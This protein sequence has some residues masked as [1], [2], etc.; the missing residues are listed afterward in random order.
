[1]KKQIVAL[2]L[3][4]VLVLSG[5]GANQ[6]AEETTTDTKKAEKDVSV[7][8]D[9]KKE[10]T[11]E[12]KAEEPVKLV[13]YSYNPTSPDDD[14]V[15]EQLN[16]YLREKINVEIEPHFLTG[17]DYKEKV[18]IQI[19]SGNEVD[20]CFTS[21]WAVNYMQHAGKGAFAEIGSLMDENAP[22]LKAFLGE[23]ILESAKVDGKLYGIPTY[24]DLATQFVYL[25]RKD[26]VEKYGMDV[27]AVKTYADIEPMLAVIKENEPD[28]IPMAYSGQISSL[29]S[30]LPFA[31]LS[32]NRSFPVGIEY[33]KGADSGIV[34]LY[35]T[36]M[37]MEFAKTMNRWYE[38][39]Y[40]PEDVVTKKDFT[41]EHKAGLLFAQTTRYQP[42]YE[43]TLAAMYGYE[44]IAVPIMSPTHLPGGAYGSMQAITSTCQNPEKA[45]QFIELL[46]TD[47]YVIN[48]VVFGLEG[49]HY[50][51]VDDNTVKLLPEGVS[52][53][54]S[55]Y[56]KTKSW[57][58]GN[59]TNLYLFEGDQADKWDQLI[60]FNNKAVGVPGLGFSF[61]V[62]AVKTEVAAVNNV[63][64]E[65]ISIIRTGAV[66]PEEYL[67]LANEKLQ[68][69]GGQVIIDELIRQYEAWQNK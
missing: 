15:F 10:S 41:A 24:K 38:N 57:S 67:P 52:V 29:E 56:Y 22:K 8:K 51:K 3:V 40:L 42:G 33:E 26:M 44:Y 35:E 54:E 64:D 65:Y 25:V 37:Y 49:T 63:Y 20:I 58:T 50:E 7:E 11:E 27:S 6:T 16:E 4:L 17:N 12:V 32:F 31:S 66:D 53:G 55:A 59:I 62:E 18:A 30:A 43:D 47:P 19:A 1:M 46:N 69:V 61:D 13:W 9:D 34:S 60:A 48:M 36:D 39:G 68:S 23:D 21:S 14:V 45:L 5:C 2:L 28:M